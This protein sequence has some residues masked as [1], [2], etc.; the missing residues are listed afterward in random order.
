MHLGTVLQSCNDWLSGI[1]VRYIACLVQ[2][3]LGVAA[4]RSWAGR[5]SLTIEEQPP[6]LFGTAADI[7]ND[8][9]VYDIDGCFFFF[10][11]GLLLRRRC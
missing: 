5:G 8:I 3:G 6:G 4:P 2:P 7:Y 10:F 11:C 1:K 9:D